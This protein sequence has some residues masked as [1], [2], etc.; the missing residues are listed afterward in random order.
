M[1]SYCVEHPLC[2]SAYLPWTRQ[3]CGRRFRRMSTISREPWAQDSFVPVAK[4]RALRANRAVGVSA[5]H[6]S[7]ASPGNPN[8][9]KIPAAFAP[10]GVRLQGWIV[11]D[12][13][14]YRRGARWGISRLRNRRWYPIHKYPNYTRIGSKNMECHCCTTSYPSFIC[15]SAILNPAHT[16]SINATPFATPN[17]NVDA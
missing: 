2:W 13:T 17:T 1:I 7:P 10:V 16:Q 8:C 11:A 5:P 6:P 14:T 3:E 12:I 4:I 15:P 9:V